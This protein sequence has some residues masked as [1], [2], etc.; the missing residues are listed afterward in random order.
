MQTMVPLYGFGGVPYS[1]VR[2][3]APR[4]ILDNSDFR[5]PVNQR[6]ITVC[7]VF[8]YGLDRWIHVDGSFSGTVSI[9]TDANGTTFTTSA[10]TSV[11]L[12]QRFIDKNYY[13]G[14]YTAAIKTGDGSILIGAVRTE[15][16]EAHMQQV[17]F[18]FPI[19]TTVVWAALYEGA[20]TAE[21]LP[22]YH[23]KGYGA[24][25][26]ECQRYY[27]VRSANN[28]AAVDMRPT[29]RLSSPTITSV[30]GGYAYS[31]DL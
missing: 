3:A 6:G 5:H 16:A 4:N 19:G 10:G 23:P 26:A 22:E 11:G 20:Y 12:T 14:K 1:A 27:Q 17:F 28:I 2:K 29:M 24:E 8:G 30:T 21:T 25:L 13:D 31:A 15:N 18:W 7:N 9:T